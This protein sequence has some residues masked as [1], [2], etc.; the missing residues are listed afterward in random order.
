MPNSRVQSVWG[1][2]TEKKV[3]VMSFDN[4]T[5]EWPVSDN[6][7]KPEQGVDFGE[8]EKKRRKK[9]NEG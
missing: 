2:Q 5:R 7:H 4:F 9:L 8:S 1:C 3:L 6:L